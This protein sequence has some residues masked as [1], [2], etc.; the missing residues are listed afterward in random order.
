[1]IVDHQPRSIVV[2]MPN[3]LGDTVMALPALAA[4]R[5][6]RPEARITVMGRW[7]PLLSGQG[8]ADIV[9]SYPPRLRDRLHVARSLRPERPD[10]ALL[11]ANSLEAALAAWN[12]GAKRRLG[13]DTDGRRWLLTDIVPRPWPRLHQTDEYAVLLRAE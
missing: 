10:L 8:V 1:M 3:W 5:G 13:F 11:L 2:R 7:A 4:L 12:W 6:A 9:L